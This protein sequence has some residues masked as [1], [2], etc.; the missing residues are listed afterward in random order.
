MNDIYQG[1]TG[2]RKEIEAGGSDSGQTKKRSDTVSY[3]LLAGGD[4]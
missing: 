3:A 2:K 1:A 4:K